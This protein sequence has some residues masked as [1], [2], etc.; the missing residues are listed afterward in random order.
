MNYLNLLDATFQFDWLS[1]VLIGVIVLIPTLQGLIKGGAFMF[2]RFIAGALVLL[3]AYF[4]A[5]PVAGLLGSMGLGGTIREPILSFLVSKSDLAAQA[6]PGKE[7][8]AAVLSADNYKAV[9]DMG[10]PGLFAK[11]VADYVIGV[12]PVEAS[13]ITIGYYVADA[14]SILA[15]SVIA[16]LSVWITLTIV[17]GIIH[18]IIEKRHEE[19]GVPGFSRLIGVVIGL[20]IGD[21]AV[22]TAFYVITLLTAIPAVKDFINGIWFLEDPNVMTIGKWLYE[23][24]FFQYLSGYF[25]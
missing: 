15:L 17:C 23:A 13:E 12:I 21:I 14:L 22:I 19:K 24:N 6:S 18:H 4:L 3:A 5:K 20:A 1:L 10:V 2:F 8:V 7:M 9:T 11:S 25:L 16:F